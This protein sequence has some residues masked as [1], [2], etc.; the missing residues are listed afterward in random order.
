[1]QNNVNNKLQIHTLRVHIPVQ[2]NAVD[3]RK[4]PGPMGGKVRESARE[5]AKKC[6]KWLG[7]FKGGQ[8]CKTTHIIRF[9]YIYATY[10]YL[11]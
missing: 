7:E 11:Y 10:M 9:K 2:M 6:E 8:R 1:M 4:V 5:S 3:I